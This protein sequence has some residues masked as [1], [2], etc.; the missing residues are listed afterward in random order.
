MILNFLLLLNN[1]DSIY[2]VV[3]N[4][5]R[6]KFPARLSKFSYIYLKLEAAYGIIKGAFMQFFKNRGR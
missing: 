5:S 2:L 6:L 1:V 3:I 4:Y